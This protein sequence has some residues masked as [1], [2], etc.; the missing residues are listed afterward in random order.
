MPN[1]WLC[2][3][4]PVEKCSHQ[5]HQSSSLE[6]MADGRHISLQRLFNAAAAGDL[7]TIEWL[8]LSGV[9]VSQRDRYQLTP[10]HFAASQGRMAVV[11]FLVSQNADINGQD[12]WGYT[13]L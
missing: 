2:R 7:E 10:L 12:S 3:G 6:P 1:G 13:P 8:M 11:E 5:G 9:D 4:R